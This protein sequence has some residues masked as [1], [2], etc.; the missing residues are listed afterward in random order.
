M[1][2]ARFFFQRKNLKPKKC[3]NAVNGNKSFCINGKLQTGVHDNARLQ[4]PNIAAPT[5]RKPSAESSS[6]IS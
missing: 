2:G 3:N 1:K 4:A 5:C 6:T